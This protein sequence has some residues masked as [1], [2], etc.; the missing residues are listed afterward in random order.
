MTRQQIQE[1]INSHIP[2]GAQISTEITINQYN[3]QPEVIQLLI[4]EDL[5]PKFTVIAGLIDALNQLII[6]DGYGDLVG[7]T[8]GFTSYHDHP[9][10]EH[11]L[12][13]CYTMSFEINS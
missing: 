1:T 10:K 5:T 2:N 6:N 4:G 9:T 12:C 3:G 11:D 13:L 8:L 7:L